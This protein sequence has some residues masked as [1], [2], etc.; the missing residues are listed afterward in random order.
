MKVLWC[1][2]HL[3]WL[4]FE[5][6][7]PTCACFRPEKFFVTCFCCF[8]Y[9]KKLREKRGGR[10]GQGEDAWSVKMKVQNF[11]VHKFKCFQLKL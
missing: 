3:V 8:F 6:S 1:H 11:V 4:V 9:G 10:G 2:S 7:I 5:G